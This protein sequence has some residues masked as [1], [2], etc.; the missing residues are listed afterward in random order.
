MLHGDAGARVF[1]MR[2]GNQVMDQRNEGG[3]GLA[4]RGDRLGLLHQA[5]RDEEEEGTALPRQ[6]IRKVAP[7]A[8]QSDAQQGFA[9]Q[10]ERGDARRLGLRTTGP[11]MGQ[12]FGIVGDHASRHDRIATPGTAGAEGHLGWPARQPPGR[13]GGLDTI[14]PRGCPATGTCQEP[15]HVQHYVHG[16][17]I[18][19]R[20]T[21]P[22]LDP[23]QENAAERRTVT[24]HP[25]A[26]GCA[27]RGDVS[28]TCIVITTL[29][30]CER[31][32]ST[33]LVEVPSGDLPYMERAAAAIPLPWQASGF[34]VTIAP[35]QR[36]T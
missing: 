26:P 2:R 30:A 25:S 3:A 28:P 22:S 8:A 11:G 23:P 4:Q 1:R 9:A 16:T 13:I 15:G 20:P 35:T 31:I 34:R 14:D 36:G 32:A 33:R 17:T 19:C 10:P 6:G 7:A 27:R 18:C 21:R 29:T 5:V 12:Q 24:R